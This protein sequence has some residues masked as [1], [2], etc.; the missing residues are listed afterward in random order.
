MI[1][2]HRVALNGV[3]LDQIDPRIMVKGVSTQSARENDIATSIAGGGQRF[4]RKRRDSLDITVRIGL[5]IFDDEMDEREELLEAVNAWAN[6]VPA[7]LTTTQKP[8]RQIYV[9]SVK[10]PAPG[11]PYEWTNEFTYT[12]TAYAVPNWEDTEATTEELEEG[13]EGDGTITMDCSAETVA[14]VL[15]HNV[16]GE[17]V[18]SLAL[19]ING[20][21]MAFS[22]MG[23]TNGSYL[24]LDHVRISGKNVLRARIGNTS[25]LAKRSGA[26]EFVMKPGENEISYSTDGNVVIIVSAK[27]RY[28]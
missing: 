23:L 4:T 6:T 19:M 14:D 22:N 16:S 18:D 28:L 13:D 17:Q 26:D 11:D 25:V 9:E 15:V 20:C 5:R 3:Q 27:G 24:T 1:L 2:S 7:I 8:G 10:T 12:F 21:V